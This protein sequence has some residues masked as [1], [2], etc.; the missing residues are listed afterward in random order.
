MTLAPNLLQ[1]L[2]GNNFVYYLLLFLRKYFDKS[3][4]QLMKQVLLLGFI[5]FASLFLCTIEANA[6]TQIK[7]SEKTEIID[8]Q[9]FYIHKVEK[10]HTLYSLSKAYGVSQEDIIKYNVSAKNGLQLGQLLKIPVVENVVDMSSSPKDT[11]PPSEFGFKFHKVKSGETLYRIMK[12]YNVN[13]DRLKEYN[14][15]L[16][17]NLQIGQWIKIPTEDIIIK[18]Q[19]EQLYDSLVLYKIKKRDN[20]YKLEKKYRINQA[21]LEQLNP[22]LKGLGLQKDLIIKLP[23]YEEKPEKA[24]QKII[25]FVQDSIM[26]IS[27]STLEHKIGCDTSSAKGNT[28]KVALMMPFYSDLEPKIRVDNRYYMKPQSTYNSFRYIQYYEGFL[29]AVDSLEKLGFKAEIY[30]YDTKADTNTTKDII[31]KPEFKTLDLIIGPFYKRNL[32]IVVKAASKNNTKVI[33]PFSNQSGLEYFSNL[34]IPTASDYTQMEQSI[35][36]VSDSLS[37]AKIM[38]LHNGKTRELKN[39]AALKSLI[40]KYAEVGHLDT[41]NLHIYNYKNAGFSKLM[42]DIDKTRPN[43]IINLV[44]DEAYISSFVRQ[45]NQKKNDSNIFLLGYESKWNKF[46]TLENEYLVNLHLTLTSTGFIDYRQNR[47]QDF[48]HNFHD[49]Y[50]IDP[51]LMAFKGFDQ[52]FYFMTQLFNFGDN[53]NSCMNNIKIESLQND[54]KFQKNARGYWMNTYSNIYQYNDFQLVD[55]KR[56]L[57]PYIPESEKVK[58]AKAEEEPTNPT[59]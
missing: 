37:M 4:K 22:K 5:F 11:V 20:Y 28:Y 48:V 13:L 51:N 2:N 33:S 29:M 41:N 21:A 45:L 40:K 55:K 36:F 17:S 19:A 24:P 9:K 47:V 3:F 31:L 14:P 54:Y 25:E 57:K 43:V 27:D 46:T 50:Q 16:S 39:V 42:A 59:E 6:Q 23:Y 15:N 44:N 53:F 30:V 26:P 8:G 56:D 7:V 18:K 52:G 12:Q 1:Q 38:L 34:F 35:K 32:S 58:K 49:E 10:G